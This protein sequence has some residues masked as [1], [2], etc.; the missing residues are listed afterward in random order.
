MSHILMIRSWEPVQNHWLPGSTAMLLT[1]PPWPDV[2][3]SQIIHIFN[4]G[5]V[6]Q[7]RTPLFDPYFRTLVAL[8]IYVTKIMEQ[9]GCTTL[10]KLCYFAWKIPN[11]I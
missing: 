11:I 6:L 5:K 2:G 4:V 7:F 9:K 3:S 1:Q 10:Q 8:A